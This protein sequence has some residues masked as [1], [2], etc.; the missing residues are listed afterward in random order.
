MASIEA[1]ADDLGPL[2]EAG[3]TVLE[4][5]GYIDVLSLEW[6]ALAVLT[7]CGQAQEET[8]LLGVPC[9][10]LRNASERTATLAYGTNTLLGDDPEEI[11]RLATAR[12]SL[13][14]AD[15]PRHAG[16]AAQRIAADLQAQGLA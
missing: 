1:G 11:M 13:P 5:I 3:A 6:G 8:T 10:T 9:F 7:D 4:P 15:R 2:A 12:P 16:R 14:G